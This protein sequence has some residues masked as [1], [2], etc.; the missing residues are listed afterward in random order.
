MLLKK[1]ENFREGKGFTLIEV[2]LVIALIAILAGI[3]IVA[4]NPARQYGNA[5]NAERQSHVNTILNAIHQYAVDNSGIIPTT[6]PAATVC[7]STV[8]TYAICPTGSACTTG[9]NLSVLTASETYMISIPLNPGY[10]TATNTGYN[11]TQSINGRVTVCAP[12]TDLSAS[13][14][15]KR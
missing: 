6:I 14:E 8:S 1:G 10:S 9:V 4:I 5:A 3:T 11:V 15:A 7:T 13:I 2:L 12:Y